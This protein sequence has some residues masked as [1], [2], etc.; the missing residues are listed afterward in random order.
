MIGFRCSS[1]VSKSTT[2]IGFRCSFGVSK[3]NFA[4]TIP[5]ADPDRAQSQLI[6]ILPPCS[7][8][9]EGHLPLSE[10]HC[11]RVCLPPTSDSPSG[12]A[13]CLHT[14]ALLFRAWLIIASLL[15]PI[16]SHKK[17]SQLSVTPD[18]RLAL[19]SSEGLDIASPW[20]RSPF[21]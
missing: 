11:L 12:P 4:S 5:A 1:G 7:L 16:G 15:D 21:C 10:E 9:H 19:W 8:D 2:T 14:P 13:H 3:T 18:P 20:P 17:K 6:P